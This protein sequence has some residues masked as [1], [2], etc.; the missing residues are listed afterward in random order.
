MFHD[1]KDT[2]LHKTAYAFLKSFFR[3]R[4]RDFYCLVRVEVFV[5]ALLTTN[6][7]AALAVSLKGPVF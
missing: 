5:V 6:P 1:L 3:R 4:W 2:C 7:H